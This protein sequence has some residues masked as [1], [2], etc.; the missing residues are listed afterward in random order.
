MELG[1][2]KVWDYAADNY[3]HRLIQNKTDGK[4]VQL[5]DGGRVVNRDEKVDSITLEVWV[6]CDWNLENLILFCTIFLKYTYLLT[7]QLE[8]QRLF[9][10]DRL[11]KLEDKAKLQLDEAEAKNEDCLKENAKLKENIQNLNKEKLNLEKKCATVSVW[12]VL[13]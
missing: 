1:N 10:E 13:L 8:S 3:V 9:F 11:G 5:D 7:M 6:D 4:L 12:N 2:N